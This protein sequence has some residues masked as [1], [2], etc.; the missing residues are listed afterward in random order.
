M[1]SRCYKYK[2]YADFFEI[3]SVVLQ[4]NTLAP[5]LFAICCIFVL[6]MSLDSW[7]ELEFTFSTTRSKKRL[8]N[9]KNTELSCT[10]KITL[11]PLNH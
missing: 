7:K 9:T 3:T 10:T 6:R 4:D 11:A 1:L 8:V 5:Y 2:I